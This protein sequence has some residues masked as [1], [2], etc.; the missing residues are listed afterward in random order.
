[1]KIKSKIEFFI[2][3]HFRSCIVTIPNKSFTTIFTNVVGRHRLE[4]IGEFEKKGRLPICVKGVRM[5]L[6]NGFIEE[7]LITPFF[8]WPDD[9]A[10]FT[11]TI[12]L[13]SANIRDTKSIAVYTSKL[14]R[15]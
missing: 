14:T 9:K 3:K 8:L 6:E 11:L 1:M 13:K 7:H 5:T 4:F 12:N 2:A 15:E 10:V